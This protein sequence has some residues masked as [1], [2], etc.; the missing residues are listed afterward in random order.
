[1]RSERQT[2]G[3]RPPVEA[4]LRGSRGVQAGV[5]DLLGGPSRS[6]DFPAIEQRALADQ[7]RRASKSIC[8]NLAEGFGRQAA[9]AGRLPA[10]YLMMAMGSADEMRVW[11]RYCLDLGYIDEATWQRWRQEYHEIAKMLQGLHQDAAG[12]ARCALSD[13]LTSVLCPLDR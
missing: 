3:L 6:L 1:M 11:C 10:L 2:D 13:H 7:V 9:C 8:A 5:S 12:A 4:P